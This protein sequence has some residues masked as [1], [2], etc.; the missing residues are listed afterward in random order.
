[1]RWM[2][3]GFILL[4]AAS[5][6]VRALEVEIQIPEPDMVPSEFREATLHHKIPCFGLEPRLLGASSD[7]FA[8]RRYPDRK[9]DA[10]GPFVA[11]P[12]APP[13]GIRRRKV[14]TV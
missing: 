13:I 2:E 8:V 1:M 5:G 9:D 11:R 3:K 10:H 6:A 4:L 12:P 14:A 7:V